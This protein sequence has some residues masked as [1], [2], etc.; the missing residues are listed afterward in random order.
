[1]AAP[2]AD[3]AIKARAVA[4]YGE[5]A[6]LKSIAAMAGCSPSVVTVWAR[7]AGL[8]LRGRRPIESL[9]RTMTGQHDWHVRSAILAAYRAGTKLEWIAV[10]YGASIR[11]I[12]YIARRAGVPARPKPPPVP[13]DQIPRYRK[14]QKV[15]GA[16]AAREALG[17][18]GAA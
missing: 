2:Q 6:P 17:L 11:Q 18:G 5:G 8:P 14:L 1:M 4:L 3:P 13:A 15:I 16:A 9:D 12:L 7:R 10:S